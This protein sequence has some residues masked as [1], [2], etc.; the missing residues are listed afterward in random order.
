MGGEKKIKPFFLRTGGSEKSQ[1]PWVLNAGVLVGQNIS[2][3]GHHRWIINTC[4]TRNIANTIIPHP[5][6][7]CGYNPSTVLGLGNDEGDQGTTEVT[8]LFTTVFT[9]WLVP[10]ELIKSLSYGFQFSAKDLYAAKSMR[11]FQRTSIMDN[12][13]A[14][15][16]EKSILSPGSIYEQTLRNFFPMQVELQ[17]QILV[18]KRG[19]KSDQSHVHLGSPNA[20]YFRDI[21]QNITWNSASLV[22]DSKVL[23]ASHTIVVE[24]SSAGN[25]HFRILTFSCIEEVPVSCD[26]NHI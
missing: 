10:V 4:S 17:C 20:T 21:F 2:K 19:R 7:V 6:F 24:T 12:I 14:L 8:A 3:R 9:W 15:T 11:M 18:T 13:S 26:N 22:L 25:N 1:G 5:L 16:W 23:A